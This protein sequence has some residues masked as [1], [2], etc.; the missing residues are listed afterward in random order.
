MAW[1]PDGKW[2]AYHTHR[3]MSD[4]VWLRPADVAQPNKRITFL[5]RGAEVG[6]PRWSPDGKTVLLNGA[7]KSDGASVLYTIAVDQETG[8]V[9][10]EQREVAVQGITGEMGHAEWLPDSAS[11]VA[12]VKEAPGR[13][14]I[15]TVPAAGG[16]AT[17]V[18]RYESEHDFA[19]LGIAPNGRVVV[20]VAPAP[21][22]YFQIFMKAMEAS[23]PPVQLTKDPS[24]K[25]QPAF[26][27]DGAR[28]AF[29]VWSYHAAF[30]AFVEK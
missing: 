17:V 3:E 21:D 16:T 23:T 26:S 8:A 24:H 13:H 5:G 25:T 4:D 2:I 27:P 15:V 10:G 6:W 9:G 7:R 20:F 11:V 30:W 22:G 18:H 1:S 19:G 28:V 14:A 29:T 12:L